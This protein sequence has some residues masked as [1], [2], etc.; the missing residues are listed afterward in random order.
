MLCRNLCISCGYK[1]NSRTD[2]GMFV[3]VPPDVPS[4]EQVRLML[5]KNR[6]LTPSIA[7]CSIQNRRLII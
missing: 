7:C 4:E 3:P 2:H 6:E 1:I 5:D